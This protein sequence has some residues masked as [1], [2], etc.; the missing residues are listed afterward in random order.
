LNAHITATS[1]FLPEK[2]LTNNDLEKMVDTSDE[3]IQSRTG[4][5]ER[6]IVSE[7]QA[8]AYMATQV[9]NDLLKKS[10]SKPEEIDAIIIATVTPDML[11]PSTAALVQN[12][13]GAKNAWGYDLSGACSGFLF[14]LQN[15][16]SLIKSGQHKKVIVIGA[17]TMSSIL[18]WTDRNTCVL[19]GDG[20][21]GVLLEPGE[22]GFGILDSILR[23]DG[24]GGKFLH[25]P[26]GGSLHP[27]SQDTVDKNMHFLKQDGKSV[28]K[29]AVK[30]MSEISA[31]ILKKNNILGQDIKLFIPHQANK[32][33]IDAA[34]SRC[35]MTDAQ[36]LMNIDRYGNTTAG[37]IPI[38]L[39]EAVE[40]NRLEDGDYLL[41]AAFGAGF[42]LGS[43]LIR[44]KGSA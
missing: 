22:E 42:T 16:A 35:G 21:G 2:I 39:D 10:N 36:V 4:I 23:V 12:N 33:I 6:R 25:L 37:T 24:S 41:L 19:F 30:G 15:G 8:T 31:A 38:G 40:Q 13:I 32:R 26:A 34:A 28:F 14:A 27:A 7:G 9:A 5:K 20:G 29:F 1:R 11:F 43:V 17:D 44:W 3:W 18:D